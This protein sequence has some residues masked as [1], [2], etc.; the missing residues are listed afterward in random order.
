MPLPIERVSSSRPN[1]MGND[2]KAWVQF[3]RPDGNLKLDNSEAGQCPL[4]VKLAPHVASIAEGPQGR[5]R[6]P[7]APESSV[8]FWPLSGRSGFRRRG[9]LRIAKLAR[10]EKIAR[11]SVI[12]SMIHN[13]LVGGKDGAGG[14]SVAAEE[15]SPPA[16]FFDSPGA[17]VKQPWPR[18]LLYADGLGC[19]CSMS[20]PAGFL[21]VIDVQV[22]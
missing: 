4:R 13:W 6:S 16:G 11:G 17:P 21:R 12:A 9:S 10:D 20:R 2:Q 14:V 8:R 15:R 7:A 19:I 18:L 22:Y 3:P 5:L 1:E